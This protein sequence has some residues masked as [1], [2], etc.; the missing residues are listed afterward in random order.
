MDSTVQQRNNSVK[1]LKNKIL[2]NYLKNKE[3]KCNSHI[4]K[5]GMHYIAPPT[6]PKIKKKM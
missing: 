6:K 2:K 3:K 1:N 4:K 5:T